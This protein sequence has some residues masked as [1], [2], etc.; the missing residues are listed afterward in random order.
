MPTSS[1]SGDPLS[2][3]KDAVRFLAGD[4][5][6]TFRFSDEEIMFLLETQ[7]N[8]YMAAALLCEKT[9]TLASGGGNVVSKSIG[10]MSVTFSQ[11]SVAYYSEQAKTLRKM[12]MYHQVPVI[13]DIVEKFSYRQFDNPRA[14]NPRVKDPDVWPTFFDEE[15]D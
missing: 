3:D 15:F 7:A 4:T 8:K 12:G 10:G 5:G 6:P 14:I 9:V 2:T 1:Y 13:A 11:E